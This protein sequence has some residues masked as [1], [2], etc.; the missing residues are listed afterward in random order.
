M[1]H[2]ALKERQSAMWGEGPFVSIAETITDLHESVAQALSPA[3]GER[4]LDLACGT[5]GVAELLARS[6]AEVVGVDLAPALVETARRRASER[7]LDIDYRVGDCE[8]LVDLGDGEFDAVGSS[9]GIMF[10]PDHEATAAELARVT[11][12]GARLA[13]A[14]WTPG[15]GVQDMF[16]LMAPFQPGPPP[17]SPF[18][19]GEEDKVQELLGDAFDLRFERRENVGSY[20]SAEAY[21]QDMVLNYGPTKVL[22]ASLGDR[23]DELHRAWLDFFGEGPIEHARPYLLVTGRRR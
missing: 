11:K 19:W 12:P 20:P 1:A 4:V 10:S 13:L 16:V 8:R 23:G 6:G 5:G 17:S 2:E 22:H 3:P 9:V 15:P 7:G 14:G 21:W 18:D